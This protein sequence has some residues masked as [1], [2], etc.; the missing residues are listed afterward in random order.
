MLSQLCLLIFESEVKS[1]ESRSFA[2]EIKL[3]CVDTL[4]VELVYEVDFN[5]EIGRTISRLE[6]GDCLAWIIIEEEVV[7]KENLDNYG[8]VLRVNNRW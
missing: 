6:L 1:E 7:I 5:R 4:N 8:A 2:N 3:Y